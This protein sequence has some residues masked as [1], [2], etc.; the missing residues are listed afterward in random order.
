MQIDGKRVDI[1]SELDSSERVELVS[2]CL[3]L[4]LLLGKSVSIK[5]L[6]I[7]RG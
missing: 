3:F 7:L 4:C 6:T 1:Y 2:I 5:L